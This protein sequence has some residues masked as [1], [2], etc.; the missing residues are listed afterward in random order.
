[1]PT[2][3]ERRVLPY[4]PE[5][6][7]DL[8]LDVERYPEF[9]PWA[10]SSRIR[11]RGD[12]FI[13]A[14]VAIGFKMVRETYTSKASY[15]RPGKIE[16]AYIQGPFKHLH[17]LWLFNAQADGKTELNFKIDFDFRS[18]LLNALIGKLFHEAVRRMV[19]AFE[20]RATK[21]Y[22]RSSAM[23]PPRSDVKSID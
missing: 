20:T 13:I 9:L 2:H 16:I 7:F 18:P 5:Q 10:L 22:G 12:G 17:S 21:L 19:A 23:V 3:S 6:L 8:V 15:E 14:D 11:K 1:M 4:T